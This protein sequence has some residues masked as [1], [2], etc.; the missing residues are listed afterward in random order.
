[1]RAD[2]ES[3]ECA[4]K[5]LV[6]GLI[7]LTI[8]ALF[9]MANLGILNSDVFRTWWPLLLI[10]FGVAKLFGGRR[11]DRLRRPYNHFGPV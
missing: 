2:L 8:G 6:G 3:R 9:L 1:M 4:G 7:L 5:G 11:W 10:V